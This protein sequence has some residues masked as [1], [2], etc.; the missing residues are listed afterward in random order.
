LLMA[1]VMFGGVRILAAACPGFAFGGRDEFFRIAE[2]YAVIVGELFGALGD[3]HH[4]RTF[5]KDGARSLDGIFDA[6]KTGDGTGAK[7]AGVHDDG[8]AFDVAIEIQMGAV[9]GVE[10]RI[11]F[12][13]G[14][15]GFDGVECVAAV[16]EDGIAGLERAKAAGF[17]GFNGGV[18][19][20]PGAAVYDER[21]THAGRG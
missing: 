4:M 5:F 6:A 8:V 7:C 14:N 3:E 12:E 2:R 11:V 17:A 21:R 20:V 9:A 10:D 1:A 18:R 13:D 16:A 19:D 15:G